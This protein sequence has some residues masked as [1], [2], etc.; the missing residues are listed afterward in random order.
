MTESGGMIA[1]NNTSAVVPPGASDVTVSEYSRERTAAELIEAIDK[2]LEDEQEVS[3][4]KRIRASSLGL[5]CGRRLAYDFLWATPPK[6][7]E[8]RMLRLFQDGNNAET[9]L[10]DYLRRIGWEVID[11]DPSNPKKQIW[12][13]AL[14][15]HVGGF[16]DGIGRDR[17]HGGPWR[18]IEAKTHS[19]DSFAKLLRDTVDI[20]KPEH[21]G[22]FAFYGYVLG[23]PRAAYIAKNKNDSAVTIELKELSQTHMQRLLERADAIVGKR[24]LPPKIGS[25]PNSFKCRTCDHAAGVC[26]G[27]F[28]PERNCRTCAHSKTA[29]AATWVCEL[30]KC[31]IGKELMALGC[32]QYDVHDLLRAADG[33]EK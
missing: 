33:Q 30:H 9:E 10:L 24:V 17:A 2:L 4:P 11:R 20:A 7:F 5:E 28:A 29:P 8:G 16:I 18:I 15:G 13:E 26:H 27:G 6:R 32:E 31:V 3:K 14:D 21:V 19:K 23:I 25:T 22:Q 12:V 1:D